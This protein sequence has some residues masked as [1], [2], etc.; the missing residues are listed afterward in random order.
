MN[1][2]RVYIGYMYQKGLFHAYETNI[3]NGL[4][5]F[6]DKNLSALIKRTVK[7]AKNF[8]SKVVPITCRWKTFIIK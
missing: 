6:M 1:E 7:T 2:T 5:F 8:N 4:T 3:E